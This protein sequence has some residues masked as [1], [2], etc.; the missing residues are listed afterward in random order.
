M[1]ALYT[2]Q[3]S[4][5]LLPP[6]LLFSTRHFFFL[7]RFFCLDILD[8]VRQASLHGEHCHLTCL[9]ECVLPF[10]SSRILICVSFARSVYS[11]D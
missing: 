4:C 1:K 8:T 6:I 9:E 11:K 3:V 7:A 2:N 10:S 5:C